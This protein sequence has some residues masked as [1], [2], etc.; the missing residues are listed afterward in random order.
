[1]Q[2]KLLNTYAQSKKNVCLIV[3]MSVH[4][5]KNHASGSWLKNKQICKGT[6]P[7]FSS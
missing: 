5:V 7:Y 6:I 2:T 1:M 3:C 4:A